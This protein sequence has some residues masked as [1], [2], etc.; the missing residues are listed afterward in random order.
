MQVL[1]M[2]PLHNIVSYIVSFVVVCVDFLDT[3]IASPVLFFKTG[4]DI[5]DIHE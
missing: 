1:N 2:F 3:H 4:Y 5:V